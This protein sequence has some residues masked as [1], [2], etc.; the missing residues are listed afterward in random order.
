[1]NCLEVWLSVDD[2]LFYDEIKMLEK[3]MKVV[4][5]KFQENIGVPVIIKLKEKRSFQSHY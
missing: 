5:D 3:L 1:M 2:R 4:E